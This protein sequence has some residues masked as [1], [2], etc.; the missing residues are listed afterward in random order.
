MVEVT[1]EQVMKVV[2]E[3]IT[4]ELDIDS[5]VALS[6][7]LGSMTTV[8]NRARGLDANQCISIYSIYKKLADEVED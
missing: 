5:A 7:L 3:K 8:D 6:K 2:T 4:V 1:K